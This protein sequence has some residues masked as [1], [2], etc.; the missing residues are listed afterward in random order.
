MS[1]DKIPYDNDNIFKKILAGTIPSYK[2]F[3]TEHAYAFLDAFPTARGHCLL[4]PKAEGYATMMDL[5]ED[6]AANVLKEL[7]RLS[8]AVKE[9]T[10]ADGIT[11]M[12][13]NGPASG[14][15]VFHAHV[16]VIP[17]FEGDEK[18]KLAGAQDGMITKEDATEV[19]AAIQAKLD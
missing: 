11:I 2:I 1:S 3:E 5:P 19:M 6:V 13:N 18:V 7:P 4:I 10:A 8:R 17:R 16:H 9:A 15:V 14:Q 12:Q